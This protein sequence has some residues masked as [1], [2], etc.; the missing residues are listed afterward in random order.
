[1]E[2]VK[3]EIGNYTAYLLQVNGDLAVFVHRVVDGQE[4]RHDEYVPGQNYLRMREK[5]EN[6]ERDQGQSI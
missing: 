2:P 6:R 1:M 5:D 4:V 3:V